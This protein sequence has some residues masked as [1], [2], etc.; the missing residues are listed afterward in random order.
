MI[1]TKIT[2]AIFDMDGLVFDSERVWQKAFVEANKKF[3]TDL[4]EE[5]RCG[6]SGK[7]EESIRAGLRVLC[8]SLDADAYRD[9]MISRVSEDIEKGAFEIK[10]G[11]ELLIDYFKEKG[12]RTAL[13]TAGQ[14]K[15]TERMF[16]VKGF[17]MNKLFDAVVC[18]EDVAG[19]SKPDPFVFLCAAKKA[20]MSVVDTVVM[21]DSV[22][23]ITAAVNGGFIPVMVPDLVPC[24]DYCREHCALIT[25][26]LASLYDYIKE[27]RLCD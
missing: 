2:G 19:H 23:G 14:R 15:R 6:I 13:A 21:E 24:N 4:T 10:K 27:K 7:N 9:F 11:F 12:V 3:G 26:S 25:E 22:N 1:K 17:D 8:P 20:G 16:A 5:Y 18:S